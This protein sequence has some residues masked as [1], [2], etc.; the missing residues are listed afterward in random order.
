VVSYADEI[1]VDLR[2][3]P[4][5]LLQSIANYRG[6][7][8]IRECIVVGAGGTG[9]SRG[10]L[11]VI[12]LLCE[13]YP[14]LRVL[15]SRSTRESMTSSTLVEWEDCFD[16]GN[17][18]IA[19]GPKREGRSIYHFPNG[20]EVAVIGLDKPGKLFSTKWDIIYVEELTGSGTE[21]GVELDTW[22]LFYRGL[23]GEN[24]P[25]GQHLLIGSCNPSYPTHWVKQ[26]IDDGGCEFFPS[27]HKDNPAYHDGRDWTPRG[28]S[29]LNG[30]AHMSGHRKRRLLLGE[31]CAA[32]GQVWDEWNK[33]HHVVDADLTVK[34][35]RVLVTPS[36][37]PLPIEMDWTFASFDWGYSDPGAMGVWGV[38]GQRRLWMLAEIYRTR[39]SLDWWTDRVAEFHREFG[40]SAVVVDP[41][42][43]DAIADFNRRIAIERGHSVPGFALGADNKRDGDFGGLEAVRTAMTM[44]SD[45]HPGLQVLKNRMR[46]G[47][48]PELKR[49][50]KPLHFVMEAPGYIYKVEKDGKSNRDKTDP[51]CA[52][53][54][55]DQTRYACTYAFRRDMRRSASKPRYAPGTY[56]AVFRY[57]GEEIPY[58]VW[59]EG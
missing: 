3:A 42:R 15:L 30:L 1:R 14:N 57:K 16:P 32:E 5:A 4:L 2:G 38:D 20:S 56:G 53:H 41:S 48:D 17:P 59:G 31:W 9:K 29:Y 46:Y 12:A 7:P 6:E 45:G 33:E 43:N 51:R 36:W 27:F 54:A 10:I 49:L 23:R 24:P 47:E 50:G 26:R 28:R 34:P 13:T 58:P 55:C 39:Q 52:D 11:Q 19:D 22:E 18:V 35:G 37:S 25:N 21:T 40:I 8:C 44:R